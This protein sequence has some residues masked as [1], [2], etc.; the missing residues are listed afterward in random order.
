[1]ARTRK[2]DRM[3][4]GTTT[5]LARIYNSKGWKLARQQRMHEASYICEHPGCTAQLHEPGACHVHHRKA[6]R[7]AMALAYEPQNH[8]ALCVVHHTEETD[9]EIAKAQGKLERGCD[10]SGQPT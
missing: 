7:S 4:A 3:R 5:P 1:M 2:H 9:R 6:L 10:V 8:A